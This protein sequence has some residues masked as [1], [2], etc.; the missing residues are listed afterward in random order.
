VNIVPKLPH[1]SVLKPLL[2][3]GQA[4]AKPWRAQGRWFAV[5]I[6]SAALLYWNG[7][8]VLS[9]GAGIGAMLGF[10]LLQDMGW[11]ATVAE[12]QNWLQDSL[13]GVNQRFVLA[14]LCGGGVTFSTYLAS[15]IWLESDSPWTATGLILQ[16][17]ATLGTLGWLLGRPQMTPDFAAP[18]PTSSFALLLADLTD[19]DPLKRLIAVRQIPGLVTTNS[20]QWDHVVE[21]FQVLLSREG[22][23][24]VRS[25]TL[26]SLQQLGAPPPLSLA[27]TQ[28]PVMP[29]P[30]PHVVYETVP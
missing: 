8:L 17:A 25:A 3:P 23:E 14:A 7:R 28:T 20:P 29:I 13:K 6:G 10:Y 1:P 5:G 21:Y 2:T 12:A 26:Q 30:V 19:P 18:P 24:M 27:A 4:L 11:R 9:T 15:S 22:D 16:G